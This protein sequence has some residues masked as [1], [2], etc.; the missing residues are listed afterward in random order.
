M[1]RRTVKLIFGGGMCLL[2]PRSAA[3]GSM[4][5]RRL[6]PGRWRGRSQR[7]GQSYRTG[8]RSQRPR[9]RYVH[10]SRDGNFLHDVHT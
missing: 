7:D 2:Q 8:D 3:L 10:G 5:D 4:A 1:D 6:L 9:R